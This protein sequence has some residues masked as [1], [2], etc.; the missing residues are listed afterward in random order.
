MHVAS[1][2]FALAFIVIYAVGAAV[3]MAAL[4]GA[5]GWPLA[6]LSRAPRC[7][8]ALVGSSAVVS[9]VVGIAWAAPIVVRMAI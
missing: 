4:A 5:L 1:P 2:V 3:G 9:V 8:R 7:V 6:R